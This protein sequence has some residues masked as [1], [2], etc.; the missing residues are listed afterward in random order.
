MARGSKI[1]RSDDV[2]ESNETGYPGPLRELNMRRHVR[3]IADFGGLTNYG[4][5][6]VRVVPG[7]QSSCR[8]AHSKQDELVYVISG[9]LV[10][11]TDAG[12]ETVGAGTWIGFPAGT[13]DAHRFVNTS[14][15]DATFLVVGDRS[16]GDDVIYPD[17]DLALT[18][19]P[20]GKSRFTRKDGSSY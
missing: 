6:L 17:V 8:H 11:E 15:A 19:G 16:P 10:L 5:N 1:F 4:V 7:G 3:R 2:P 18:R 12:R 20:D 13:G 9:E 14:N